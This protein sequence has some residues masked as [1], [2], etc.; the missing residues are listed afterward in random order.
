MMAVTV[1]G[2]SKSAA[3]HGLTSFTAADHVPA[4]DANER[5]V[6]WTSFGTEY[7]NRPDPTIVVT[8]LNSSVDSEVHDKLRN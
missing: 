4:E 3:T 8:K 5:T 1:L 7:L 6:Q 2:L